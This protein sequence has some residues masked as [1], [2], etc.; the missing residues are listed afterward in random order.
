[1]GPTV[2]D[3]TDASQSNVLR[4]WRDAAPGAGPYR[5]VADAARGVV[6]LLAQ[7]GPHIDLWLVT[8]VPADQHRDHHVVAAWTG[9]WPERSHEVLEWSPAFLDHLLAEGSRTPDHVLEGT[10]RPSAPQDHGPSRPLLMPA[11]YVASPVLD[12][13]GRVLGAVCGI[14]VN[15]RD[16]DELHTLRPAVSTAARMLATLLAGHADPDDSAPAA[17]VAIERDPITGLRNQAGFAA[18]LKAEQERCRV[19]GSKASIV[20]IDL[21]DNAPR[22]STEPAALTSAVTSRP[23]EPTQTSDPPASSA[24][25]AQ[26]A[27]ML[28]ANC[29]DCDVAAR[30]S[31]QRFAILAVETDL[32]GATALGTR[33]RRLLRAA[34]IHATV[35][36]A[37]RRVGE[38][39]TDTLRRAAIDRLGHAYRRPRTGQPSRLSSTSGPRTSA[40]MD[41]G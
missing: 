28:L 13:D 20:V 8:A 6:D 36:V 33:L 22:P 11:S 29:H 3:S 9:R 38:D 10:T 35:G 17:A 19:Y 24:I 18:I 23:V 5:T 7:L 40:V 30:L 2:P 15:H 27:D 37:G 25:W 12:N 21:D 34:G 31:D 4:S 26:V 39:L 1:M 41:Q 14:T 16:P 32:L